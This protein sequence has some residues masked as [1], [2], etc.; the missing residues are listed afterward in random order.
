MSEKF[1]CSFPWGHLDIE[2]NGDIKYCCASSYDDD[3]K[4]KDENN[5][6]YNIHTHSIKDAWNSSRIR[7]LRQK[8]YNGE[9]APECANCWQSEDIGGWS[10]RKAAQGAEKD[11]YPWISEIIKKSAQNNF[12]VDHTPYFYQIQ[13][14]NLCNLACK[15]CHAN[16]STTYGEFYSEIYEDVS[17]P[18]YQPDTEY[19][20]S[21][22]HRVKDPVR[23]DWPSTVGLTQL[24]DDNKLKNL[25]RLYLSG[26]EPTIIKENLDFLEKLVNNGYSKNIFLIITTNITKIHPRFAEVLKHFKT[27]MLICSMDAVGEPNEIQ[28][29]PT[30]YETVE[31]NLQTYIN[32]SKQHQNIRVSL[33]IVLS[34]LTLP[35]VDKLLQK[36]IDTIKENEISI[37]I[38]GVPFVEK[39]DLNIKCVPQEIATNTA[40]KLKSIL[41]INKQDMPSYAVG[42]F[43]DLIS[44]LENWQYN[45]ENNYADI[46]NILDRIQAHHPDRNIKQIFDIYYE[47]CYA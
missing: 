31:K 46:H 45:H 34:C 1:F 26:G 37:D 10:V 29:Y 41:D 8:L 20:K 4:F 17:L 6:H 42:N 9:R 40:Q 14:G 18:K 35:Y 28:R 30:V 11:S 23:F 3:H 25:T 22:D 36:Y 43:V 15:M 32:L 5:Q 13:T 19:A 16:Y 7:A 12:Y 44:A 33:N 38:A 39:G 47:N 27:A 21:P 24:I 2:T